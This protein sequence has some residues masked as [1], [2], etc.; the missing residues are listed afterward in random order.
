MHLC[1]RVIIFLGS[2]F[3]FCGISICEGQLW[4]DLDGGVGCRYYSICGYEL[5]VDEVND[6]LLL[7]GD[8]PFIS[9]CET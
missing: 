1:Q 3:G 6:R 9:S 7:C 2:Y 8:I 5:A 4:K